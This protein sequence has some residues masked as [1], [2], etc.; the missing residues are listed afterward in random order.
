[1][2]KL[3]RALMMSL[4]GFKA[5]TERLSGTTETNLI[6]V[7]YVREII[8]VCFS[9]RH[10]AIVKLTG[11]TSDDVHNYTS[12]TPISSA[13]E[14][15]W[16]GAPVPY[17]GMTGSPVTNQFESVRSLTRLRP[18]SQISPGASQKSPSARS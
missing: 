10:D 17:R 16:G 12:D 3:T 1:M 2:R 11:R 18:Q 6:R 4:A 5:G 14:V 15:R 8:H 13:L 9:F 7:G